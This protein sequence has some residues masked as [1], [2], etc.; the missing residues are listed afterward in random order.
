MGDTVTSTAVD[1]SD[2]RV[3]SAQPL[4]S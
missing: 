1:S 4:Y 2:A 3:F